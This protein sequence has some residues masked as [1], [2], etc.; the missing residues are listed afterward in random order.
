[1]NISHLFEL[2][3]KLPDYK[4]QFITTD[5]LNNKTFCGN[6]YLVKDIAGAIPKSI[7]TI[8]N[9]NGNIAEYEIY[10]DFIFLVGKQVVFCTQWQDKVELLILPNKKHKVVHNP[11][12]INGYIYND[13][14]F[15]GIEIIDENLDVVNSKFVDLIR[16]ICIKTSFP[17]II[18]F[19]ENFVIYKNTDGTFYYDLINKKLIEQMELFFFQKIIISEIESL[20]QE[21]ALLKSEIKKCTKND[22]NK[23]IICLTNDKEIKFNPCK[24]ILVCQSCSTTEMKT[25]PTCGSEIMTCERVVI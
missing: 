15:V 16:K 22:D 3:N 9:N 2:K 21:V 4:I 14:I 8:S 12:L 1:M 13:L 7:V 25:C 5:Q 18:G 23:C 20:K 17:P 6:T 11:L 24:H 10:C 19:C